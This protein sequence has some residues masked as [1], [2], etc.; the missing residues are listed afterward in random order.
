MV[1]ECL[2]TIVLNSRIYGNYVNIGTLKSTCSY[3][4]IL[5]LIGVIW[6]LSD[7]LFCCF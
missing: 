2:I 3:N 5:V 1:H 4:A 7:F 6:R